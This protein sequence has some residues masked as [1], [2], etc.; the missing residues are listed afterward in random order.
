[1]S[2]PHLKA[3]GSLIAGQGNGIA[4][5]GKAL[6]LRLDVPY[7]EDREGSGKII[8]F[9]RRVNP[10]G[11]GS[12]SQGPGSGGE[13]EGP[14]LDIHEW[15][16]PNG[17]IVPSN[18]PPSSDA[19][20]LTGEVWELDSY[21]PDSYNDVEEA[22]QKCHGGITGVYWHSRSMNLV[23]LS[24]SGEAVGIRSTALAVFGLG[25]KIEPAKLLGK[26]KKAMTV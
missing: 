5:V 8:G 26:L 9:Q 4:A 18:N 15:Q 2:D 24:A 22:I 20:Q 7:H 17:S 14:V 1:M 19:I 21:G 23:L 10:M 11:P 16:M 12:W 13:M 3:V 6:A 25:I